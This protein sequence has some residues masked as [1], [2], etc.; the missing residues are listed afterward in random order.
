MATSLRD[1]SH[2][3]VVATA[4]WLAIGDAASAERKFETPIGMIVIEIDPAWKDLRPVPGGVNGIAFEVG[5]GERAM[6]LVLATVEEAGQNVDTQT[7]RELAEEVRKSELEEGLRVSELQSF[8]D[9]K[10]IAFYYE[11]T[12]PAGAKLK[13]GEYKGMIAGYIYTNSFPLVF[14][15]AYNG[16]GKAAA[17][18][19]FDAVKRLK[20]VGR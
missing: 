10:L 1:A 11:G 3:L 5:S 17:D 16:E 9:S 4:L 18:R 6:Q 13:P 2:A 19:A 20:I 14:T 7:V 8:T 15:I 12:S